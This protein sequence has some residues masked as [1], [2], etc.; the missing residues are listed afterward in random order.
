MHTKQQS[1]QLRAGLQL[2]SVLSLTL[3]VACVS[4]A[5]GWSYSIMAR[6]NLREND[7]ARALSV[8]EAI[9][10]AAR[11]D[12]LAKRRMALQVLVNDHIANRTVRHVDLLD[13]NGAVIASASTFAMGTWSRLTTL[14]VTVSHTQEVGDTLLTVVRPIVMKTM[15]GQMDKLAGAI[16]LVLDT[17]ATNAGL[18]DARRRIFV[19]ALSITLC[20]VP[21]GYLLVWRIVLQPI[22][23]LV[24]TTGRIAAGDLTART[25]VSRNDEIGELGES[26]D[27][28]SVKIADM[29][30]QLVESNKQLEEKVAER[31]EDLQVANGR[32]RE[33]M[34]E[35]EDFLRAVSH[36]LNAPL[37]NISGMATMLMTN[38][39]KKLPP[40]MVSRLERIQ[41]NVDIQSSLIADLLELSRIRAGSQHRQVVDMSEIITKLGRAFEFELSSRNITFVIKDAMPT[42]YV[43]ESH[44]RQVFQNLIDN[45]IKYMNRPAG[46]RI[47]VGYELTGDMHQFSIRDNGPGIPPDEH[48]NVFTVFRRASSAEATKAEG[49]GVG[50]ATVKAIASNYDGRV[51]V[52]S[53]VGAGAAFFV[54]ISV[55]ATQIPPDTVDVPDNRKEAHA[56][57]IHNTVG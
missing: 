42:L 21:L 28:M 57:K 11:H 40:E 2:K 5:G 18:A 3:L 50:L 19:I 17:S 37:R 33:E 6:S 48:S 10:V 23:K 34:T 38:H 15:S 24:S 54:A 20:S 52:E 53:D 30:D 12:L 13:S 41:A 31:T 1:S 44:I 32:L 27:A 26:F 43:R 8:A 25:G 55:K 39:H 22:R 35:K 49:K 9:G 47:E 51:W 56:E 16:R 29:R 14:P 36:D 45:A 4:L 46:G 7:H